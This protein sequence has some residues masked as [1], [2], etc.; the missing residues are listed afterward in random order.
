M[1]DFAAEF[2]RKFDQKSCDNEVWAMFDSCK[3]DGFKHK[4]RTARANKKVVMSVQNI[5]FKM[6]CSCKGSLYNSLGP[7]QKWKDA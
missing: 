6:I 3:K 1:K 2:V 4:T 5:M 7:A